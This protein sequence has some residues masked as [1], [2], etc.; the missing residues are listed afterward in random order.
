MDLI[1]IIV[2]LIEIIVFVYL[3][4]ASCYILVF[5]IVGLFPY[6]VKQAESQV[7][8]KIAVLIPGYKEDTVILEVARHALKQ[9]Y[10]KESYDVIVIADS[11]QNETVDLLNSLPIKVV[12]VSFEKSTKSKA[13]NAAMEAIGDSYEIAVILD[14]DNLMEN[15]FLRKINDSFENGFMVVQGHR[16]AKNMN[17]NLALLD[18][19]SEEINNHIFRKGHRVVGLSSALIGSGMAFEYEFF[20][21]TMK[22]IRAIGGFDKELELTLLK[23][24]VKIE[25]LVDAIVLDEKVQKEAVFENQRR[26][27][28]SAQL[29]YFRRYAWDGLKQFIVR[30]NVD[31]FDKVYQMIL[32]PRILL[33]GLLSILTMF[34]GILLLV[35][36]IWTNNTFI[37]SF[38]NWLLIWLFTVAAMLL[39]IPRK[40]Y[41][42][43]TLSALLT[44]PRGFWLMVRSL[45]RVKNANKSF[46]HTRHGI[47]P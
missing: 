17:N 18:T 41:S 24:G 27:W 31:Y 35:D 26:R 13:L 16:K 33:L 45:L 7:K 43:R 36:P 47:D 44:L 21:K 5:S 46:I 12:E 42:S 38:G 11:F 28:I 19:V 29:I 15:G 4:F 37:I 3:G 25:Y 9:D 1:L 2:R 30:F 23:A 32:P 22:E 8:R 20:K 10:P 40:L 14:A 6:R 39:A 34:A